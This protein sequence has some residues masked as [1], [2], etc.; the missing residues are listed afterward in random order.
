[1]TDGGSILSFTPPP[2]TCMRGGKFHS[3]ILRPK[4]SWSHL[5]HDAS[6]GFSVL[7]SL[8]CSVWWVEVCNNC[9][10]VCCLFVLSVVQFISVDSFLHQFLV[11]YNHF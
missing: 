4:A 9:K 6:L 5:F 11:L 1:M 3:L 8:E 7:C 2:P 10:T